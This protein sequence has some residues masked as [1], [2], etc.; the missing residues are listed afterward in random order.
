MSQP[1][2]NI[3]TADF[4]HHRGLKPLLRETSRLRGV[5]FVTCNMIGFA[6]VNAF[7]YYLTTGSPFDFSWGS[8]Q[9]AMATPLGD[10]LLAPLSI[11]AYPW[12]I[13]VAGLLMAAVA[14][15]P[16]MV[17]VLY[18][19]WVSLVFIGIVAVLGHAP[20]LAAFLALG[21]VLAARTRLRSDMP[22][23]ATLLGL[24]PPT[25]YFCLF[26]LAAP[27]ELRSSA[28]RLV[29]YSPYLL[30]LVLGIGGAA[31]VVLMARVTQYR[32]GVVWPIALVLI[33]LPLVV[34]FTCVG[35]GELDFAVLAGKVE[36]FLPLEGTEPHKSDLTAAAGKARLEMEQARD[37]LLADCD[38]YLRGKARDLHGAEVLWMR[39]ILQDVQLDEAALAQGTIRYRSDGLSKGS[40]GSWGDLVER[41]PQS[42]QAMLAHE[43]LAIDAL[44][45]ARLPAAAEHL[46]QAL[47][48]LEEHFARPSAPATEAV[49]DQVFV[50][51]EVPGD[52][53]YSETLSACKN[54]QWLMRQNSVC[55][56]QA[57]NVAAFAA[58]MKLWPGRNVCAADLAELALT[59]PDT[60]LEDN[61]QY[62]AALAEKS[63]LLRAGKLAEVARTGHDAAI[64]AW[65]E[66]GRLAMLPANGDSAAWREAGLRDAEFYFDQV[67]SAPANPYQASAREHLDRLH[68]RKDAAP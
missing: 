37:R 64:M 16:I 57:R 26:C 20:V 23:L 12:M 15:L 63:E 45:G 58:Y 31:V 29:L 59:C 40:V 11:F 36:S 30:A 34:F 49:W 51:D 61:Y 14:F 32:P 3:P 7:L 21:A 17:A 19:V 22:F 33:I 47:A 8:Y 67:C 48:L 5:I 38:V 53:D 25:L 66:L 52:V 35:P 65:F 6:L 56:D 27:H 68:G 46:D 18:R 39:A 28:Q 2:P 9:R 44:R 4:D 43:R 24:A 41:Y 13:L 10:M 55:A 50:T 54:V 42:P 62:L 1:S 60:D